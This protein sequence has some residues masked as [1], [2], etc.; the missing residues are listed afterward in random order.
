MT[1]LSVGASLT[2]YHSRY[3]TFDGAKVLL[4]MH[5]TKKPTMDIRRC[6]EKSRCN[7]ATYEENEEKLH[8]FTA[9]D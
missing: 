5:I 6:K 3:P 7:S 9:D 4:K 1:A 8:V 2:W